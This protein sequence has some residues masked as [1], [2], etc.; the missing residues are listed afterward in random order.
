MNKRLHLVALATGTL[1]AS[2]AFCPA[3]DWAEY[4]GNDGTGISRERVVTSWPS[5]GPKRL[6]TRP[7]PAGFSSV[8][9]EGRKAF[10]VI[11]RESGGGLAEVCIALDTQNGNE[12]ATVELPAIAAVM[13]HARHRRR[14][15]IVCTFIPLRCY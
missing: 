3:E 9:V 15:P 2:R 7:T 14:A 5:D 10:T 1:L 6:W 11:S 13:V 12:V 8:V 4:R